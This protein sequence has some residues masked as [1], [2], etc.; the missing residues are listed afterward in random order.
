V[1]RPRSLRTK[2][3]L[4]LLPLVALGVA[5]MTYVAATKA[6]HAQQDAVTK[7]L[8]EQ[9][10]K[11]ANAF[12]AT[13]AARAAVPRALAEQMEVTTNRSRTDIQNILRR[14]L[15]SDRSLLAPT[16]P[17]SPTSSTATTRPTPA[18]RACPRAA[19][20]RRTGTA[21]AAPRR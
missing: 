21:S 14:L 18:S 9:A 6:T 4:T 19:T 16:S 8:G 2:L 13:A 10:A 7:R 11:E 12:D 3:I 15:K 1:P 5:A 17:T 20:S